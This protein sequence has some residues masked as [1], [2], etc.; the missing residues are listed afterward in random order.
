MI[1]I[2]VLSVLNDAA[3][4]ETSV[5]WCNTKQS[6]QRKNECR[7]GDL[8]ERHLLLEH[9]WLVCRPCTCNNSRQHTR[10]WWNTQN[11]DTERM[12]AGKVILIWTSDAYRYSMSNLCV[13]HAITVDNTSVT[14][15]NDDRKTMSARKVNRTRDT[16]ITS[17]AERSVVP[18]HDVTEDD[19]SVRWCNTQQR[20]K[21]LMNDDIQKSTKNRKQSTHDQQKRSCGEGDRFQRE[22]ETMATPKKGADKCANMI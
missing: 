18:A 5:K 3:V 7:K 11:D 9:E 4:G 19:T 21:S 20:W 16:S 15:N 13:E 2:C 12:N 22:S 17:Q 1:L 6:T 10:K 8:Y 14:H